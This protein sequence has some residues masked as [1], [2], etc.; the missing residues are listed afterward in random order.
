[1]ER[2]GPLSSKY[3]ILL[4]ALVGVISGLGAFI[5]YFLLD[6]STKFFL[7]GLDSFNPLLLEGRRK[8]S[9][10]IFISVS[11]LYH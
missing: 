3:L 5:F 4:A 2:R 11:S 7:A 10:W 9:L 1:M 6:L 8:W